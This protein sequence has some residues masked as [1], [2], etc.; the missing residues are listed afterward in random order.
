MVQ[1]PIQC[2]MA[3]RSFMIWVEPSVVSL[4]NVR[5]ARDDPL[6][7]FLTELNATGVISRLW[8]GKSKEQ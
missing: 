4:L 3:V 8:M 2:R 5:S 7:G 1:G 6:E